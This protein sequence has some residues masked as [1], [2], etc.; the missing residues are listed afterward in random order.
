MPARLR[1]APARRHDAGQTVKAARRM[2]RD[3]GGH[4]GL[5][6]VAI[7]SSMDARPQ[8][9]APPHP[10]AETVSDLLGEHHRKLD[11]VF[12]RASSLAGAGDFRTAAD[13]FAGFDREL[14]RHIHVEEEMLFPAF[15]RATGMT[16]G[17][18][19]VMRME[20]AR[21]KELLEEIGQALASSESMER[22]A[23]ELL[24]VLGA[25]NGKEE[26]ILYP[27]SDQRIGAA[28]RAALV[29]DMDRFL[30]G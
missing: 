16:S 8:A 12:D 26:T 7:S 5:A 17:P 22:P 11:A 1:G 3:D 15:E 30:R 25:H 24:E 29:A 13:L 4:T 14:R 21:I 6:R 19:V 9:S 10:A 28:L 27:M 18:T 2:N 20:H 23:A